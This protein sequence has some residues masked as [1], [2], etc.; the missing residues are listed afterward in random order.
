MVLRHSANEPLCSELGQALIGMHH[1]DVRLARSAHRC[2]MR[3]FELLGF[4]KLRNSAE[5]HIVDGL[6]RSINLLMH[7]GGAHNHY[8]ALSQRLHQWC[9]HW[10]TELGNGQWRQRGRDLARQFDITNCQ[11]SFFPL[12][13]R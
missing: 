2:G 1:V 4:R 5:R 9:Q 12:R 8:P 7:S 10:Q 11:E 13:F 6:K 3:R